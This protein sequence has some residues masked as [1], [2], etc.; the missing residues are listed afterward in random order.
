VPQLIPEPVRDTRRSNDP[1][2][3]DFL[4]QIAK[5]SKRTRDSRLTRINHALQVAVPQLQDLEL[6]SDE[7]S[8]PHLQGRYMQWRPNT[9]RQTE[10]HFSDGTLRLLG[11]LWAFL[12]G[13]APLLH[14]EPELSLHAGVV[15]LIPS[16]IV[17]AGGRG[18]RQILVTTHSEE[19]LSGQ[20]IA[21]EEVLI[22]TPRKDGTEAGLGC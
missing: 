21:T 13:S 14:E 4:E 17:K 22:L 3:G 18:G 20:G 12:A 11:L 15:R 2:D 1:L 19:Q 8:V 7:R 10:E 6:M 5:C 9:G 16:M